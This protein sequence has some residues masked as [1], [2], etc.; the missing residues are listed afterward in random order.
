MQSI[1]IGAT[2]GTAA[3]AAAKAATEA[4][5]KALAGATVSVNAEGTAA[6][7]SRNADEAAAAA[8]AAE[9]AKKARPA[10]LPEKFKT[11]E[12]LAAAYTELEKKLGTKP[13]EEKK[14]VTPTGTPAEIAL[15]AGLD[16]N[17]LNNEFAANGS[18]SEATMAKLAEKGIT[19]EMVNGYIEG[20]KAQVA[21]D[22]ADLASVIGGP[23]AEQDLGTL[24][25]WAKANL[26]PDEIR[27]YNALVTGPTRNIPA[28]KVFLDSMLS[29]Y[30]A[31]LGQD[32]NTV[33]NGGGVPPVASGA[34]PFADSSEIIAAMRDPRY[35]KSPAYR[36]Q[37]E[38]RIAVT[39]M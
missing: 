25:E 27:G 2:E 18:L 31:A 24:Y 9:E 37:V 4:E 13:A 15:K 5:A 32:P 39:D 1:V 34:Q 26:S 12:E 23:Q 3:E 10:Y 29:R 19:P 20:M 8:K 36:A 6:T 21:A 33:V 38:A 16:I 11:P 28:A 14:P 35:E 30:N 7:V 22:R 17:A